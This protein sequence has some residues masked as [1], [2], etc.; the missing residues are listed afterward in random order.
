[1]TLGQ[2]HDSKTNARSSASSSRLH[3]VIPF[4]VRVGAPAFHSDVEPAQ[5]LDSPSSGCSACRAQ[6]ERGAAETF[7]VVVVSTIQF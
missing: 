6:T 3:H 2:G 7:T 5:D 4:H 1:M